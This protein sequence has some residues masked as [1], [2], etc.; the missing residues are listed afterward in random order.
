MNILSFVHCSVVGALRNTLAR[1]VLVATL[2]LGCLVGSI[3]GGSA[4]VFAEP[5][6]SGKVVAAASAQV[7]INTASPA[8]LAA[9]LKGVGLSKAKAIVRYREQYGKFVSVDQLSEVKGIGKRTV[10]RNRGVLRIK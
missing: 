1:P 7:N 8:E 2:L 10:E 5:A 3:T 4:P 9:A 6:S